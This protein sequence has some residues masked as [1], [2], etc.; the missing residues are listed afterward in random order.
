VIRASVLGWALVVGCIPLREPRRRPPPPTLPPAPAGPKLTDHLEEFLIDAAR[1]PATGDALPAVS[2]AWTAHAQRLGYLVDRTF[3]PGLDEVARAER[4]RAVLDGWIRSGGWH[5]LVE[6]MRRLRMTFETVV[7]RTGGTFGKRLASAAEVEVHLAFVPDLRRYASA[8][9]FGKPLVL[10]NAARLGASDEVIGRTSL[11]HGLFEGLRRR[12]GHPPADGVG[13]GLCAEAL[14]LRAA[15]ATFPT[16]ERESLAGLPAAADGGQV[17]EVSPAL[18]EELAKRWDEPD[19]LRSAGGEARAGVVLE[20]ERSALPPGVDPAW[21]LGVPVAN[22]V[23]AG[24]A[25]LAR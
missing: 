12:K 9:V 17:P 16:L 11:V 7:G 19:P 15:Q 22:C 4:T 3:Y 8:A 18:R 14:A 1:A 2:A 23:A 6:Q 5:P 13:T 24:R 20:L 21:L 25:T 10:L